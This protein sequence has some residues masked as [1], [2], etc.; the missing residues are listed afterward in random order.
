MN[1]LRTDLDTLGRRG[2]GIV[3][4]VGVTFI[5]MTLGRTVAI[6]ESTRGDDANLATTDIG[7]PVGLQSLTTATGC[8]DV[9]LT[10]LDGQDRITLDTAGG[11]GLQLLRI[12]FSITSADYIGASAI[13]GD[14]VVA[15]DAFSTVAV[16]LH[17][18]DTA[19]DDGIGTLDTVIGCIHIEV[20][21]FL[22]EYIT[23]TVNTVVIDTIDF[24]GTRAAHK[25]FAL[26]VECTLMI[27]SRAVHQFVG[28]RKHQIGGTL[29]L[30]IEGG[31]GGVVDVGIVTT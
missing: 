13:D 6:I 3:E 10:A 28:A 16:G 23:L 2:V 27:L 20:D 8:L 7:F 12:P 4:V 5:V 9:D 21:A 1:V 22:E 30:Q 17:I 18:D 31:R 24:E 29:A 19:V 26:A 15:I 11:L 14:V 25:Q